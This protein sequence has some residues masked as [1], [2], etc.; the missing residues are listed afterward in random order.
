MILFRFD[1]MQRKRLQDF[2]QAWH[3]NISDLIT[4]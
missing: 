2:K 4:A 1:N 3:E